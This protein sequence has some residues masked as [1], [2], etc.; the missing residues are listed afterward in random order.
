MK[1]IKPNPNDSNNTTVIRTSINKYWYQDN[2]RAADFKWCAPLCLITYSVQYI[3]SSFCVI[4]RSL[5]RLDSS[6]TFDLYLRKFQFE[7]V[8]YSYRTIVTVNLTKCAA[9]YRRNGW[10]K[11]SPYNELPYRVMVGKSRAISIHGN[12]QNY[13]DSFDKSAV[14]VIYCWFF[15]T[16]Q[17]E[18][19]R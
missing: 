13:N 4:G 19:E 18:S 2:L 3:T 15:F 16:V 9:W 14:P 17:E 5:N 12:V 10:D 6:I 11:R 1:K 7:Y 8:K